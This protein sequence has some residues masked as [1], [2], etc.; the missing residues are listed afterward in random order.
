MTWNYNNTP[1]KSI[2]DMPDGAFGFA[3]RI[4]N[5]KNGKSYIGKKQ[6]ISVTKKPFGKKKLAEIT[7]KRSKTYE[8]ISKESK[9]AN[10]L[11][12]N[13]SLL[14]DVKS[15]HKVTKTILEYGFSKYHLTY[16]EIKYQFIH[17]VL[18]TE[19]FYNDNIAS[20]FFR[21]IFNFK[22]K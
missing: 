19:D 17:S 12:S 21:S 8:M 16:L 7:D 9:W 4:D 20:K 2:K 6:V 15:G 1:I 22:N 10:Y 18:E 14:D 13:K 5:L 11:G 3:Y